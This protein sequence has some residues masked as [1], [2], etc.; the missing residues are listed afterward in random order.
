MW[1]VIFRL[2]P[3]RIKKNL[4]QEIIC[5]PTENSGVFAYAGQIP[6]PQE[7]FQMT[8]AKITGP[9]PLFKSTLKICK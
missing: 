6:V 5:F 3:M 2:K 7:I 8:Q 1:K 9:I 4:R